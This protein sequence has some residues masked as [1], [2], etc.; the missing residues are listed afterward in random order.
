MIE[1][2][3]LTKKYGRHLALDDLSFT[4]E[5][6]QI[7]GFLGPNGAGKSTTM[8]IMT[9][10]ISATE[11]EVL[12]DGHSILDDPEKAKRSI[13]YLPEIPPLYPDMTVMEYLNFVAELKKIPKDK[14]PAEVR[15]ASTLVKLK[16][17][18]N[19]LIRNLSKGYKQ[20]TGLAAA[21]LGFPDIIILD[22][23]TVGL[24]PKQIIEIRQ[25]IRKL[26]KDHT[27]I[28]SSHILAEVQEICDYVLI[29]S[30]GKL[31]ASGT[32]NELEELSQGKD[33]IELTIKSNAET[34]QKILDKIPDIQN[35]TWQNQSDSSCELLIETSKSAQDVCEDI[36]LAF[37]VE[38]IPVTRINIS[39]ATLEDIFLELT[40]SSQKSEEGD[41]K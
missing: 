28:L 19:R 29:I 31:A 40:E 1:V 27:V 6:G 39:K 8:N 35:I 18:S 24:D 37:A 26:A 33:T 10:Y 12:I 20:R 25:L 13:G 16:D 22:E 23:P 9:G 17:V 36:S 15:K 41:R 2:Q 34:I 32:P 38:R 4:I 30:K 5:K 7:Y 21:V 14:R 3:H 11:G